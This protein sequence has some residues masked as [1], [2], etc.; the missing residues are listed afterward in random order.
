MNIS[1]LSA[2]TPDEE[3]HWEFQK[4]TWQ[5]SALLCWDKLFLQPKCPQ[6][7]MPKLEQ[8]PQTVTCPI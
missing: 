1:G 7:K 3:W 6:T 4:R 5:L 2:L 8:L